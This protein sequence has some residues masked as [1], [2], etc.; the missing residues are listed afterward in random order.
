MAYLDYDVGNAK[1]IVGIRC[2]LGRLEY[3]EAG[4]LDTAATWSVL[5][6]EVASEVSGDISDPIRPVRFNTRLGDYEGTL[7]RIAIQLKADEGNDLAVDATVAVISDWSG[8]TVF[9]F[10]GFLDRIRIALDPGRG[11]HESPT[12]FFGQL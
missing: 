10:C 9:G 6:A 12:V 5:S 11:S 2:R 1:L 7:H 8:P 4:L 3:D